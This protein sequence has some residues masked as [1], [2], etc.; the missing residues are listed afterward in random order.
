MWGSS[1]DDK[2]THKELIFVDPHGEMSSLHAY[3]RGQAV[4]TIRETLALELANRKKKNARPY[5]RQFGS[6]Y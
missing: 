3:G 5:Y 6:R 1:P 4:K 2:H